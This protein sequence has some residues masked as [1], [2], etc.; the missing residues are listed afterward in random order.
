[1][2]TTPFRRT[3]ITVV[4]RMRRWSAD[5]DFLLVLKAKPSENKTSGK[6]EALKAYSSSIGHGA[7]A[8]MNP[9]IAKGRDEWGTN[10]LIAI[11]AR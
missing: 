6:P 4:E 7:E 9:L 8:P 3:Q 5:A 10:Q 1:M 11:V 2:T